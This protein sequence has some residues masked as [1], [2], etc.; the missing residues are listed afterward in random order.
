MRSVT[1]FT[2]GVL[3]SV[4]IVAYAGQR[5][6]RKDD[7]GSIRDRGAEVKRVLQ[8]VQQKPGIHT[9]SYEG[10]GRL[11]QRSDGVFFSPGELPVQLIMGFHIDWNTHAL[12]GAPDGI[13]RPGELPVEVTGWLNMEYDPE[14]GLLDVSITDDMGQ[15]FHQAYAPQA[16]EKVDPLAFSEFVDAFFQ[17]MNTNTDVVAAAAAILC[18][19]RCTFAGGGCTASL[20][21]CGGKCSSCNCQCSVNPNSC[22]CTCAQAL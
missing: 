20:T 11:I 19:C 8:Q 9:L 22:S 5:Q 18:S 21:E 15:A 4:E 17:F 10:P 7:D 6:V 12:L 13:T 2:L 14:T 3:L 1:T 16:R